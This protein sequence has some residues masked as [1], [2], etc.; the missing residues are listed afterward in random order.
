MAHPTIGIVGSESLLGKE[1]REVLRGRSV[2]AQVQL[3][4]SDEEEH[5]PS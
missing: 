2:A 3:I 5:K 4:G 1:I